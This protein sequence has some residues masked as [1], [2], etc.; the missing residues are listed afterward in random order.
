MD[1][2]LAKVL[3]RGGVVDDATAGKDEAAGDASSP[4]RGAAPTTRTSRTPAR[5][6]ARRRYMAPEQARGETDRVD[7]RADVF[8]LGSILCEILTGRR[9]SPAAP[10]ARSSQGGAGRHGRR[11]G[12][13]RRLRGRRRAGRAGQGLPGRASR[14]TARAT[15]APWPSGSRPT[16]RACR[17]ELAAPPSCERAVAEARAV[18]ERQ[19]RDGS[20][21]AL[22]ASCWR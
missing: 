6:W 10:R 18:E 11:P 21:S 17:S 16:W 19:R 3:P 13:A 14:R 12:P 7:E 4:R 22:A 9:P 20:S 5:S 2:G 8:A 15:P 1:W